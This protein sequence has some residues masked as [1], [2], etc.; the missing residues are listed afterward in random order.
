VAEDRS[1]AT[2]EPF[3]IG[4]IHAVWRHYMPAQDA[5][6]PVAVNFFAVGDAAI[7]TN[8][9]YGRGCSTSIMHANILAEVLRATPDALD[10]A[11]QFDARTEAE[12]RPIY[13][14]SLSEDKRGIRHARA[15]A[16]GS[17]IDKIDSV[18]KWFGRAFGDALGA[19]SREQ[20][21]VLRG[22]MRTFHLLEKPGEFLKD[23]RIKRTVFRYMLRG[24]K[25]N[26]AARMQPGPSRT[27]LY[28]LLQL[29]G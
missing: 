15:I 23:K 1:A 20:I 24:R 25:R 11:R 8:P 13:D 28:E 2:T 5:N 22:L 4:D 14:A 18:K 3:G 29:D 6:V 17:A 10:R 27:E 19:A 12:L 26:T 7:R 21:H 9:L 16:E